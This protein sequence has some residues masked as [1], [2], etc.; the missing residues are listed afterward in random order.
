ADTLSPDPV[1]PPPCDDLD[2]PDPL[3]LP[4]LARRQAG[5][6]GHLGEA[7]GCPAQAPV[8]RPIDG[9]QRLHLRPRWRRL[10][11]DERLDGV[12]RQ[13]A[14]ALQVLHHR[15]ALDEGLVV[16]GDVAPRPLGLGQQPFANVEPD[17]LPADAGRPLQVLHLEALRARHPARATSRT[18]ARRASNSC[19]TCSSRSLSAAG[20]TS[21]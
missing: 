18:S 1:P 8:E 11:V 10:A 16:P 20:S 13:V 6:A 17:G 4:D 21:A 2:G 15:D 14:L 19:A 5:L 7:Y 9:A 12:Q 3:Q